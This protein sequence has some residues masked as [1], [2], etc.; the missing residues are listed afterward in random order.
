[1]LMNCPSFSAAPLIL[2]R[3][4]TSRRTL[5]SDMKTLL[6]CELLPPAVRRID[7]LAA[8]H[9]RDAASASCQ[10]LAGS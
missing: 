1:M 3:L 6:P 7:S 9:D 8:P 5:A 10:P 4:D 2:V